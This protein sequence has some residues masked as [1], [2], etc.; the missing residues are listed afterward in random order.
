VGEAKRK[1]AY[2]QSVALAAYAV[3]PFDPPAEGQK[4]V[5]PSE[6]RL[7]RYGVN[8]TMK[9]D[10]VFDER[11][12]E[13]TL[14]MHVKQGVPYMGDYEH[15]SLVRPP[16]KAPASITEFAPEIRQD[17]TGKPELWATDVHWTDDAKAEVEAG[18]YRLYSPA[19]MPDLD[20]DGNP[21][22]D[23][24]INYLINVSLTN[25]PATYGLQPL[26]AASAAQTSEGDGHME[27]ELKALAEKLAASEKDREEFKALCQKMGATVLKL[28]GKSFDD[29]A[30]EESDEHEALSESDEERIL[31]KNSKPAKDEELKALTAL[32]ATVV[33]VTGK[34]DIA[35]ASGVLVTLGEQAKQF[36]ALKADQVKFAA[37]QAEKDFAALLEKGIAEF[38]I[39]PAEKESLVAL[40]ADAGVVH[41]IKYLSGRLSGPALV[42]GKEPKQPHPASAI[43]PERA[44]IA[45][46]SAGRFGGLVA[47]KAHLT[48]DAAAK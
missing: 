31:R 38:K 24:H 44:Q 46:I 30:K 3:V 32:K 9:G 6:F 20:A 27:E 45:A 48:D 28:T 33:T 42:N 16:I 36:V 17:S 4:R 14:A 41:A 37:E 34:T 26:V 19:F 15:M 23:N 43:T 47:L 18:H 25:L 13:S 40:K 2:E 10:F 5:A 35:E 1:R 11:S 8:A 39:P 29:W 7:F 21:T 12:A 22:P